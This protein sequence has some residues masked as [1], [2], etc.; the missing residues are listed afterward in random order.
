MLS[1]Y[2]QGD[3]VIW[4]LAIMLSVVSLLAIYSSTGS[5]AWLQRNGNTEYY[6]VK[7]LITV[8][9]GL[10]FMFLV[11]RSKYQYFSY[12]G[13]I[14]FYISI[15]LLIATLMW[16][17][18]INGARRYLL[19]HLPLIGEITFQT[20]DLAKLALIMY[21]ARFLAK[22]QNVIENGRS[23]LYAIIPVIIMCALIFP[24]N[25]STA[26]LMFAGSLG[27]LF[28]GRVRIKHLAILSGFVLAAVALMMAVAIVEPGLMPRADTW[29][30]RFENHF[31]DNAEEYQVVQSKTAIAKGGLVRLAPG[32][33]TQR[34]YL[35]HAYSDYVYAIIIEEYGLLGGAIILLMFIIILFRSI[36]IARLC[37][38]KFGSYLV[39][40][41]SFMMVFQA[42]VNMS[43]A[44]DLL[45]V[46]GQTLPFISMGGTS[47][48]FSCI[49]IGMILSVSRSAEQAKVAEE[50]KNKNIA[51]AA[52]T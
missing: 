26:V 11:H 8:L 42:L 47:Y 51:Y 21:L 34:N 17:P 43:V 46:T 20:S 2:I 32:Q 16:G 25:L 37:Q 5:L 33:S 6:L 49:G 30:N 9:L 19:F 1:K 48:W 10:F 44:V 50:I 3:K 12:S 52:A 27:L 38:M 31:S 28:I 23:F 13:L 29:A 40:G 39:I 4:V 14:L 15:P 22:K 45:P 36:K 24:M 41:I 35:P 7:Q 18:V